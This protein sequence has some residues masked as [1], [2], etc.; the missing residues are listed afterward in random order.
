MIRKFAKIL[1]YPFLFLVIEFLLILIFTIFFNT[2]TNLEVGSNSYVAE[3]SKFLSDYKVL[4]SA[5]SFI[6]LFPLLIRKIDKPKNMPNN[7]SLVLLIGILFGLTFNLILYS[8]N[9]L[10]NFIDIFNDANTNIIFTII[11]TGIIGPILEELIFRGITYNQLKEIT[12]KT[13]AMLLTSLIFGIFHGNLVQFIYAFLFNIILIRS[14]ENEKNI[15]APIIMH[16]GA[17]ISVTVLLIFIRRLSILY[18]MLLAVVSLILLIL[19]WYKYQN[20]VHYK[21]VNKS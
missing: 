21:T 13:K 3:L 12:S 15:L 14:Y 18:T 19:M 20:T 7:L 11:S 8:L 10:F 5:L 17:N 16:M 2:T 6:I 4:I 9:T 1:L